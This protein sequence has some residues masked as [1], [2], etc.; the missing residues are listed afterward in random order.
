[1][2]VE[3]RASKE[4][5][6]E[7]AR[8]ARERLARLEDYTDQ[9]IQ[10]ERVTLRK[11]DGVRPYVADV[12]VIVNGRKLTGHA[13]GNRPE[14]AVDAVVERLQRRLR[15][16]VAADVATRNEPRFMRRALADLEHDTEQ[17]P[18]ASLKPP[19]EREIVQRATYPNDPMS[20]VAAVAEL[21]ERDEE[22]VIFVHER[23]R[24]DVVVFRRD[25]D[26][27]GLLHPPGSELANENDLV[28]PEPSR[29]EEPL[30][31]RAARDEMDV[32]NHRF[33]YFIDADDGRGK[34][35]YLRHDGDYGLVEPE[36]N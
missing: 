31:L 1:M 23:T 13:T 4:I 20:T 33:L 21:Y 8:A 2:D 24:E 7:E 14:Q 10:W 36:A 34:V 29:Y 19:E 22:F 11:T 18:E 25:T 6:P 35:I 3:V 17:R 30:T 9:P 12:T 26:T 27:I 28:E 5:P 32:L 16:W 15:D